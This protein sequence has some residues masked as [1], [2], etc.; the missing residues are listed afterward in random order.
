MGTDYTAM[1]GV[2]DFAT[3]DGSFYREIADLADECDCDRVYYSDAIENFRMTLVDFYDLPT[4][5][6]FVERVGKLVDATGVRADVTYSTP[7]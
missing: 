6:E 7:A 2:Y 4:L 1:I 5:V 3:V